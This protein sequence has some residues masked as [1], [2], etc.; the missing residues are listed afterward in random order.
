MG[1]L[2]EKI[3]IQFPGPSS[4]DFPRTTGVSHFLTILDTVS[5]AQIRVL[6]PYP[7]GSSEPSG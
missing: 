7:H 5:L 4:F 1:S 3:S 6:M 2:E